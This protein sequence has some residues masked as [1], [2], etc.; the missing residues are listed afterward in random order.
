MPGS[1]DEHRAPYLYYLQKAMDEFGINT[2]LRQA[3]FLAA[4]AVNTVDLRIM[5]ELGPDERFEKLY[6]SRKDLGNFQPGDGARYKGRGAFMLTGRS[7]YQA[8]GQQFGVDLVAYPE[9]AAAP[10]LAFRTAAFYWQKNG[11]NE[12]ADKSD[13]TNIAKRVPAKLVQLQTYFER[14]KIALGVIPTP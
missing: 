13:L 6:G 11:L 2:P 7:Y 12:L 8:F 10:D 14:A 3:A 4:V 1:T 5:E 9:R